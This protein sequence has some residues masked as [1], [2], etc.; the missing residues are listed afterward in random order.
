MVEVEEEESC[1]EDEGGGGVDGRAES[2][3]REMTLVMKRGVQEGKHQ[4]GRED[5]GWK[6]KKKREREGGL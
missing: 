6:K 4:Q 3:G 2:G 1:H 5:W